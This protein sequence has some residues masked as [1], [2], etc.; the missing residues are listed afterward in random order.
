MCEAVED[1]FCEAMPRARTACF[2][3]S[4]SLGHAPY[5]APKAKGRRKPCNTYLMHIGNFAH[6]L[7]NLLCA[8]VL[9]SATLHVR[10]GDTLH[11]ARQ[12]NRPSRLAIAAL[13]CRCASHRA[14][15][16]PGAPAYVAPAY[17]APGAPAYVAA[18]YVAPGAPAYV[19]AAYVAPGAP[20]YVAPAY[21]APAYVAPG[22]PARQRAAIT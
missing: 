2:V 13:S 21:V 15:V 16:A 12:P 17:V 19:A 18:A 3:H 22:A 14:Y 9:L 5:Q 4:S 20:A 7:A 8:Y 10:E 1:L 11:F 6:T